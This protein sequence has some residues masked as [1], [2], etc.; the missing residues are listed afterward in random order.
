M[1]ENASSYVSY[2]TNRSNTFPW[3]PKICCQINFCPST[4]CNCIIDN[5]TKYIFQTLLKNSNLKMTEANTM[6]SNKKH[7][8]LP[9]IK[10][11]KTYEE[12]DKRSENISMKLLKRRE[13]DTPVT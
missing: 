1:L 3:K 5:K 4:H 8:K 6:E 13:E 11:L 10:H 12:M 7:K 2:S 9:F